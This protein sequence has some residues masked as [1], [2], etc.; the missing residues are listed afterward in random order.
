VGQSLHYNQTEIDL[1]QARKAKLDQI[2]PELAGKPN[3]IE[4]RS[5]TSIEPLPADSPIKDKLV[6]TYERGR[7]VMLYLIQNG[8]APKR[9]RITAAADS[10]PPLQS[11]D[12]KSEQ[13]DRLDILQLDAFVDDYVGPR[14]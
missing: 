11:G 8:I 14:K 12:E 4:V 9:I 5:H 13:M 10:E 2:I 1:N 7:H 6:L 3:K